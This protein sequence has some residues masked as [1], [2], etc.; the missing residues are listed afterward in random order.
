MMM[1]LRA[2]FFGELLNDEPLQDI[3]RK[4][5]VPPMREAQLRE[6]VSEP[7]RLLGARFEPER[8]AADIALRAAEESAKDAGAL[9]LLS[10]L[11]DDMWKSKDPNWD[12]VLR[13]P[14]PAIEL[15]GVLVDR[16]NAFMAEH[17]CTEDALRRIF[18]LK[19]ATVREP[20]SQRGGAHSGTS[21]QTASGG[22]LAN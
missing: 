2:D 14:L 12:G 13:L 8:L 20:A 15:G 19:L 7:A 5:E 6:L 3:S 22:W 16:A 9:P 4:I 18:T 10:Y 21:F 17:P 1:S 11:L